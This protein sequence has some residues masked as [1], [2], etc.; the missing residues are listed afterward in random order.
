MSRPGRR[1][2]D[3]LALLL[4]G[5][6]GDGCQPRRSGL[7]ARRLLIYTADPNSTPMPTLIAYPPTSRNTTSPLASNHGLIHACRLAQ[8][9][10]RSPT[11]PIASATSPGSSYNPPSNATPDT[12]RP[13]VHP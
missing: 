4:L 1:L 2:G 5:E 10:V 7:R 3:S 6:V 13:T 8:P 11:P 12:S 9:W